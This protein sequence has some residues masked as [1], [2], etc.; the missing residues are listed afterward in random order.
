[1]DENYCS[2]YCQNK[3]Y[4]ASGKFIFSYVLHLFIVF[5]HKRFRVD[6]GDAKFPGF[7]RVA[8]HAVPEALARHV[9][10]AGHESEPLHHRLIN[11]GWLF[12]NLCALTTLFSLHV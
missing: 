8:H 6:A 9:Q 7:S 10:A 1:M 4:S 12:N 11:T 5:G 3:V 2:G